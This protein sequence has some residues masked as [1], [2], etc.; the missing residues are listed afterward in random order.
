M[1]RPSERWSR[2]PKIS[3]IKIINEANKIIQMSRGYRIPPFLLSR[4]HNSIEITQNEPW[5]RENPFVGSEIIPYNTSFVGYRIPI[6][7]RYMPRY[8][9]EVI[10]KSTRY[11]MFTAINH[12]KGYVILIEHCNTTTLPYWISRK[13]LRIFKRFFYIQLKP[14]ILCQWIK[15]VIGTVKVNTDG[16][17]SATGVGYGGTARAHLGEVVFAFCGGFVRKSLFQELQPIEKGLQGCQLHGFGRVDASSDSLFAVR[18]VNG[19]V[20][21]PWFCLVLLEYCEIYQQSMQPVGSM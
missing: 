5:D 1:I 2:E 12:L 6:Y 14:P 18:I 3:H 20:Q 8:I 15:P 19:L 9:R 10:D 11:C 7:E 17:V 13:N 4:A 16:S 21:P